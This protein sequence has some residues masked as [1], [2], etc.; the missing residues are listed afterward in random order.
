MTNNNCIYFGGLC[1]SV[2][3]RARTHARTHTHTHI[4]I[5]VNIKLQFWHSEHDNPLYKKIS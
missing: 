4:Y 3:A 5:Q 2:R 1:G